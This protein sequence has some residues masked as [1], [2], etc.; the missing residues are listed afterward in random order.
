MIHT[1]KGRHDAMQNR[2]LPD[3]AQVLPLSIELG[4]RPVDS[5][6]RNLTRRRDREVGVARGKNLT[7]SDRAVDSAFEIK[8]SRDRP[9][10]RNPTGKVHLRCS[11]LLLP[12]REAT[13]VRWRRPGH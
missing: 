11:L 5:T 3:G 10:I 9:H 8:P 1:H 6:S 12:R 13:D 2:L 4:R 7:K